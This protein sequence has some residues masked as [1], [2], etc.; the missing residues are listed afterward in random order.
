MLWLLTVA[1]AA[2]ADTPPPPPEVGVKVRQAAGARIVEA[3]LP[4]DALST[5]TVD[6]VGL[7]IL[8]APGAEP[9]GERSLYRFDASGDGSITLLASGLSQDLDT[10]A[11]PAGETRL[12]AGEPGKIYS[13]G[14]FDDPATGRQARLLIEGPDLDLGLLR[15]HRLLT[16]DRI[17][18]PRPRLG[19]LDVYR[20]GEGLS[21]DG[22]P[23]RSLD[24]PVRA[25]R[26]RSGLVLSIPRVQLLEGDG[27]RPRIAVGP[28]L[29]GKRRLLTTLI[30]PDAPDESDES[31]ESGE[32]GASAGEAWARFAANERIAQSWYLTVDGRPMLAV[33]ALSADKLGIFEKKKL[34]LFHLRT[35]RTRAGTPPALAIDT[36]TRNWYDLGLHVA[37]LDDDGHDDL[38][39]LQPDGLGAKKLVVEAYRGK[40]NGG[41]F[42]TPRR[43]VVV[44]PEARWSFGDDLDSDGIG[45]LVAVADERLLVFRGLGNTR[46]KGVIDKTP[47]LDLE[48]SEL[49][50][51]DPEIEVVVGDDGDS[52]SD[53]DSDGLTVGRPRVVDLDGDGTGEILLQGEVGGR[54]VLRVIFLR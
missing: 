24:L 14:E 15:R 8:L 44:A 31:G 51:P 35:D 28:E 29:Q 33:A 41:F 42:L 43:S 1:S 9:A 22:R 16:A 34:R 17:F 36:A 49:S 32:S 7:A 12:L 30:D 25:R 50:F 53:S 13:L 11:I 38:V 19:Q 52:D 39:V 46:K 4:G 20:W 23:T 21:A 10:I 40:G 54:A 5:V 26:V 27:S 47:H 18:V 48:M 45:D 3:V 37:D 6:G 2:L